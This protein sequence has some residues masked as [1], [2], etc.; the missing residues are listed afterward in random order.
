VTHGGRGWGGRKG[1]RGGEER[2]G[3]GDGVVT[4]RLG[5]GE[6]DS[7]NCPLHEIYQ[8]IFFLIFFR[9]CYISIKKIKTIFK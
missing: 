4:G 8:F 1:G 7:M 3:R 9:N 2:G 5:R 6:G